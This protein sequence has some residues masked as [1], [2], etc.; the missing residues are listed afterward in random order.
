MPVSGHVASERFRFRFVV[1][2]EQ[3]CGF[4]LHAVRSLR[5]CH[6]HAAVVVVDANDE[7]RLAG[8]LGCGV[9]L[10]HVRPADDEVAQAVGRGSRKHLYYWRHSPQLRAALP[11]TECHDVHADADQLFVRPLDLGSLLGPLRRGRI[12]AAIAASFLTYYDEYQRRPT[13][14]TSGPL[15]QGGLLFTNPADDGGVYERF[16]ELAV[17]AARAGRLPTMVWDDMCLLTALLGHGGPLWERLLTLSPECS[18][19][20]A[21]GRPDPGA[22]VCVAHHAGRR[23]QADMLRHSDRLPGDTPPWGT[24]GKPSR[25]TP[26]D[27]G[28]VNIP[29]ALS[30]PVPPDARACDVVADPAGALLLLFVDGHLIERLDPA[31]KVAARLRFTRAETVTIVGLGASTEQPARIEVPTFIRQG[32]VV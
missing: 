30:W 15:L 13:D 23:A 17:S 11:P 22:L 14:G 29:F 31:E 21:N 25:Y 7:P 16:W 12:V 24:S 28:A 10:L 19:V 2:G 32:V 1:R 4:V 3:A 26:L 18:Y 20:V 9:T 6:P 8:A 5:R 27:A